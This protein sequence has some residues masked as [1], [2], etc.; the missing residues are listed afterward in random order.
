MISKISTSELDKEEFRKINVESSTQIDDFFDYSKVIVKKPWGYEYLIYRNE[1][2]AVWILYIKQG[3][4]TSIHCHPNK[5]TSL[6]ILS[7]EALCSFLNKEMKIETGDG[8]LIDK[9]VFHRTHSVSSEGI[10]VME[11]ETPVNKRDLVRLNDTYGRVGLGYE[12]IDQMSFNLQN[13]NYISL[14]EPEVYYNIKKKFGHC[15]ISL[16]KFKDYCDFKENFK[17]DNWEAVSILKGKILDQDKTVILD[18][19]D[20]IDYHHLTQYKNIHIE[21]EIEVIIIKKRDTMIRLSDYVV[22]FLE[23]ENYKNIFLVPGSANV[24]LLD[25]IGKNTNIQHI[26]TQTEEGAVMAAE[27]FAKYKQELGIAIVASGSCTTRAIAG[28]ADAWVDSCPLLIISGQSDQTKNTPS[29][30]QLGSQ[31]I[32]IIEIAK[33]ITKYA[34]M[35]KDPL[36]IKYHLQKAIS[37]TK[38]KRPGPVWI[39]I[40]IDIQGMNIDENELI[41]FEQIEKKEKDHS[42]LVEKIKETIDLIRNAK[43]PVIIAGNG[44]R[45]AS[46]EQ[47]FLKLID[48]LSIPVLTSKRGADL[49]SD[50][51]PL[52]F[53]RPGAYGQRSANF[54][55]QN[56]DL[57]IC[58][59]TRLSIPLVGRNYQAFAREAK[60]IIVDIDEEELKKETIK[61]DV[62]ICISA[63]EF[64]DRLLA[65]NE[66]G[67]SQNISEW[68]TKCSFWKEKYAFEQDM[69]EEKDEGIDAYFFMQALS[70][71][72][73]ENA[74]ITID[75]GTPII[76][77]MQQFI[78]KTGQRLISASG[79]ENSNFALPA[80]MGV[81]VDSV[82]KEIICICDDKGF[83]RNIPELETI[84]NYKIPAKIF[85]LNSKGRS[86]VRTI[87]E[88]YFGRRYVASDSENK[89]VTPTFT[90]IAKAYHIPSF[91]VSN[92]RQLESTIKTV[93]KTRGPIICEINLSKNQQI[94]PKI[95]FTVKEN[96]KWVAKPLEDMYPFLDRREFNENMIIEQYRDD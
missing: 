39:D 16:A 4:Q 70:K 74:V 51:H 23:R 12:T 85:I 26:C 14:I 59:G 69:V 44:I 54:I 80:V 95:T 47:K 31:E 29:L 75:S 11:I 58:I 33:P 53:G 17:I 49:I 42:S 37:I 9:G 45:I 40:P 19:G 87:Q 52:Y 2:I 24:H 72:L 3:F 63:S 25:S 93:L 15:S 91:N 41:S 84:I 71:E 62:A 55:I 27:S 90:E 6:V 35:I 61:P 68:I 28:V 76:F 60:K 77:A 48:V 7:G 50:N 65:Q 1:Y 8:L 82:G 20:T 81:Y 36:E 88:S 38:D 57:L 5:K 21:G 46:A 10:F 96:G 83:K 18:V 79:L 30:R 94:K 67:S 73:T 89:L 34:V 64:I 32:N 78:F 66:K 13:Y 56:S 43:R 92:N 86:Y 22:S